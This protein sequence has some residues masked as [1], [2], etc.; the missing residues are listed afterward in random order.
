[1][2]PATSLKTVWT[3]FGT[4]VL[5]LALTVA[6]IVARGSARPSQSLTSVAQELEAKAGVLQ[7]QLEYL[8][9]AA[10]MENAI[11]QAP[12]YSK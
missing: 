5:I 9:A 1:M 2:S 10:E 4:P 8:R 3:K 11:G 7:S 12:G 6:I